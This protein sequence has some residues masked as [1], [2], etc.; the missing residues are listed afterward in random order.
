MPRLVWPPSNAALRKIECMGRSGAD[1]T[2]P[3]IRLYCLD[4]VQNYNP[5]YNEPY[6]IYGDS[7]PSPTKNVKTSATGEMYVG[8]I[9][10][11][12][13]YQIKA[14]ND[15]MVSTDGQGTK[16]STSSFII[17]IPRKSLR[18]ANMVDVPKEQK[19][20]L[21]AIGDIVEIL[22]IEESSSTQIDHYNDS[23]VGPYYFVLSDVNYGKTIGYTDYWIELECK[24][25]QTSK[26]DPARM[27]GR[28][29]FFTPNSANT[30]V[31]EVRDNVP[32]DINAI[33]CTP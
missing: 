29:S 7:A 27:V 1:I 5:V 19:I 32:Q 31:N 28:E 20:R 13:L 12:G 26:F 24:G 14:S 2:I 25:D 11:H 30:T 3:T 4:R 10:L 16:N 21:P 9:F 18:M 33:S 22:S 6:L 17:S 23:R 8:P 15:M